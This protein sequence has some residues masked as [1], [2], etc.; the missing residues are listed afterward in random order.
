VV[1]NHVTKII[2]KQHFNIIYFHILN[3]SFHQIY[4]DTEML[5]SLPLPQTLMHN[6]ILIH[7]SLTFCMWMI[8]LHCPRE[9]GWKCKTDAAVSC[10]VNILSHCVAGDTW[11]GALIVYR[12]PH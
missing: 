2:Y 10:C 12:C 1:D 11:D 7:K 4:K 9:L 3:F 6:C 5:T 8:F